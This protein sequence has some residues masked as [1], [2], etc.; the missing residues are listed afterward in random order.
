LAMSLVAGGGFGRDS[1]SG[2]VYQCNREFAGAR[3]GRTLDH[4]ELNWLR[5]YQKN[6]EFQLE[7]Y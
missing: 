7:T 4:A 3:Q 1:E 2:E 6:N 5:R